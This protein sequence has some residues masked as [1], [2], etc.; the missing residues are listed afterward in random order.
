M[1]ICLPGPGKDLFAVTTHDRWKRR[2]I[3]ASKSIC[4]APSRMLTQFLQSLF[5]VEAKILA[6]DFFT[7]L[8]L[9]SPRKAPKYQWKSVVLSNTSFVKLILGLSRRLWEKRG[10]LSLIILSMEI[11][12]PKVTSQ[13]MQKKK[14]NK[15][16]KNRS[17]AVESQSLDPFT[18]PRHKVSTC[19]GQ[20]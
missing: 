9:P 2:K 19:L 14:T 13:C 11:H 18:A 10:W 4:S 17:Q 5:L 7:S 1:T 20:S 3:L 8:G 16:F 12:W 15:K 6:S